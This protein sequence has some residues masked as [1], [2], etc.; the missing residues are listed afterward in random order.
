MVAELVRALVY[1]LKG[2]GFESGRCR[3]FFE[4]KIS[5]ISG[6]S[7]QELR[8]RDSRKRLLRMREKPRFSE[9]DVKRKYDVIGTR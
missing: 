1:Q 9:Y 5:I 2:R 3:L 6:N 4:M 7:E 8:M